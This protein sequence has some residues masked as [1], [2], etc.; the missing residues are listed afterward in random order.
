MADE[1]VATRAPESD[2]KEPGLLS[3]KDTPAQAGASMGVHYAVLHSC[4]TADFE[5]LGALCNRST[6]PYVSQCFHLRSISAE[7][8]IAVG[9]QQPSGVGLIALRAIGGA[10]AYYS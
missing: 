9:D 7:R 4:N 3:S 8:K 5:Q 10:K 6:F 1:D 2:A